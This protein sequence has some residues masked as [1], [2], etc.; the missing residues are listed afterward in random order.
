MKPHKIA[1]LL[2]L[3]CLMAAAL[4]SSQS[5]GSIEKFSSAASRI[6]PPQARIERV[7]TGF[8]WT[9]GPIWIH[10]GYLL[11]EDIPNNRMV[12]WVPGRG[13]STFMQPCGYLG[14]GVW[15]PESGSNGLTLDPRGRLTA[16]GHAQRDV[17]RLETMNPRGTRTILADQYDG[18]KLNSPNDLVYGPHG[19]LYFTDP[20]YGLP[21][22]GDK[23]PLKELKVNGVYRIRDAVSHKPGAPPD[24]SKIDLLISNLS[25]P[26]GIAFSPDYKYLYVDN[27]APQKLWMRYRVKADGTLTDGKVFYDATSDNSPGAPDGMKVDVKGN[28]YSAG[29][30]GVWIFSPAGKHLATI[31]M[32][33]RV[34]NLAWGGRDAR[35]L[36]IA[37]TTSV[38]RVRLEIPGVR[39]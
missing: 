33:E 1:A 19:A 10:A 3:Q 29:P 11:F 26:N 20:P 23:D 7:A 38:Y 39:P 28:I 22:Q 21:T 2:L 32:P 25:R 13:V 36:Y 18:K 16:A 4:A 30:G 27:S 5:L 31:H 9:E 12:K 37:A 8:K 24:H 15:G 17:W 14:K 34:G 6:I 35:T